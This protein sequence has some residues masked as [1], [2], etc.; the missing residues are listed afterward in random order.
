MKKRLENIWGVI[1]IWFYNLVLL[2]YAII[3][4]KSFKEFINNL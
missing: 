2:G 3:C 4:P 1:V